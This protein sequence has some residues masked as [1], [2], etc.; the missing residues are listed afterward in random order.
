MR[1]FIMALV[2]ATGVGITS[3]KAQEAIIVDGDDYDGP[4]VTEVVPDDD[5]D[6]DAVAPYDGTVVVERY[7]ERR[8][9]APVYGW[10]EWRPANCGSFR[11][12]DGDSCVDARYYPP[13][14]E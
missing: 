4:P 3:A 13:P 6:D 8:Y 2:L 1:A 11:Y 14:G 7:T 10:S 5:D 9:R 12:W